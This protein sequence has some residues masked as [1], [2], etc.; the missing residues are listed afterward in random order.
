MVL[1][2]ENALWRQMRDLSSPFLVGSTEDSQ[3][4][5][6]TEGSVFRTGSGEF[7]AFCSEVRATLGSDI[8]T[9]FSGPKPV[10]IRMH[11]F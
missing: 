8:V 2:S 11:Y 10:L 9:C 7:M 1:P 5:L 6:R 3:C 4:K